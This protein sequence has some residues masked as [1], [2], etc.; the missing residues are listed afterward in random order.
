MF[1]VSS[2]NKALFFWLFANKKKKKKTNASC[3]PVFELLSCGTKI[4]QENLNKLNIKTEM[5]KSLATMIN[6]YI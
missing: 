4:P 1:N 6:D 3:I 2:L 5:H